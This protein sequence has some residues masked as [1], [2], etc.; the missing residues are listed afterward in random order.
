[1]QVPCIHTNTTD[2]NGSGGG[3]KQGQGDHNQHKTQSTSK[4]SAEIQIGDEINL[5]TGRNVWWSVHEMRPLSLPPS[6]LLVQVNSVQTSAHQKNLVVFKEILP[7]CVLGCVVRRRSGD[8]DGCIVFS[9]PK[10]RVSATL[11]S[12]HELVA[13]KVGLCDL[14]PGIDENSDTD[15]ADNHIAMMQRFS[16]VEVNQLV[17][18]SVY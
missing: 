11:Q 8:D 18:Y 15:T 14:R 4:I 7:M 13:K 10:P 6:L 17:I 3:E 1:M 12:L 16:H 5:T 2:L 9:L